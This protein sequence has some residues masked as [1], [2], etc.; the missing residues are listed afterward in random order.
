MKLLIAILSCNENL[1]T[2]VNGLLTA[3]CSFDDF[4]KEMEMEFAKLGVFFSK[5]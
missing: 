5:N 3:E 4:H 2:V 1:M